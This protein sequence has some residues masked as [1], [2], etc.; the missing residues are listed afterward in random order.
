M[1]I[2]EAERR[3]HQR[4]A[5]HTQRKR[6][7][8]DEHDSLIP[9]NVLAEELGGVSRMSLHR[10]GRDPRM[11]EL[12]FPARIMM[13]GR[14]YRSRKETERFKANLMARALSSRGGAA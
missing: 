3:N 9:D 12:G 10:W 8:S 4:K 5:T 13:N 11:I 14:G 1:S 7:T 2:R 6:K